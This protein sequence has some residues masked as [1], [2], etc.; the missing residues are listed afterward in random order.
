MPTAPPTVTGTDLR[1]ALPGVVSHH[2]SLLVWPDQL[3]DAS[4]RVLGLLA[5]TGAR[6]LSVGAPLPPG[7]GFAGR[8]ERLRLWRWE[9]PPDGRP[10]RSYA[11]RA[12]VPS[13]EW[14]QRIAVLHR[15]CGITPLP[16][17]ARGSPDWCH[18]WIPDDDDDGGGG[19]AAV[20]SAQWLTAPAPAA[21]GPTA[22]AGAPGVAAAAAVPVVTPVVTPAEG[23]AEGLAVGPAEAPDP[24]PDVAAGTVLV[25]GVA[26]DPRQRRLG[27]A[28]A[29]VA[30]VLERED[31]RHGLAIT[32]SEPA[33]GFFAGQGWIPAGSVWLSRWD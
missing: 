11:G 17:S 27:L 31:V 10:G 12:E 2:R 6:I 1:L 14:W 15:A 28:A 32:E 16:A 8:P 4:A 18:A 33:A 24:G 21:P 23:L 20:A 5:N 7:I 25:A 22:D 26:A 13:P 29:C 19:V 3:N 30:G 9:R